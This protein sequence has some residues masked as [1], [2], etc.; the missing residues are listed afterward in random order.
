[1]GRKF[2][3]A[4]ELKMLPG[5]ANAAANFLRLKLKSQIT[6]QGKEIQI[7]DGKADEVKFLIKKF[8][9]RDGLD[10]YRVFSESGVIRV[11]PEEKEEHVHESR[12]DKIKGVPPFPPVSSERLPLMQTVYPNYG[13]SLVLPPRNK[14]RKN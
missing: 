2:M 9:H 13:S 8:L 3:I 1:M 10:G 14:K 6:L 7:D 12:D 5:E 11:V 4:V